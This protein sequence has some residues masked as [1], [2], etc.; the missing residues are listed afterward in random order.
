ME[1]WDYI[2]KQNIIHK[3]LL[4]RKKSLRRDFFMNQAVKKIAT[5]VFLSDSEQAFMDLILSKYRRRA[6]YFRILLQ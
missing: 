1:S 4:Q 5:G 2:M 6:A 3:S